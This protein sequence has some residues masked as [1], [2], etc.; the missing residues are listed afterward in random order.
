MAEPEGGVHDVTRERA[1]H[2]EGIFL[3]K[4][5][6]RPRWGSNRDMEVLLGR[7]NHYTR[8]PFTKL[9]ILLR[10]KSGIEIGNGCC[11]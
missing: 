8:G 6:I 2:N 7:F 11:V 5:K 3:T 9:M 4:P 1:G 10:M